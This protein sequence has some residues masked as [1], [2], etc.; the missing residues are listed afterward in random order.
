M[1][2]NK[3]KNIQT[4]NLFDKVAHFYHYPPWSIGLISISILIRG[5][6]TQFPIMGELHLAYISI[7][8]DM[9]RPLKFG[10]KEKVCVGGEGGRSEQHVCKVTLVISL[11]LSQAEQF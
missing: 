1:G 2:Q 10:S 5:L 4:N 7:L 6:Y 11:S 9:I 3:N 8:P